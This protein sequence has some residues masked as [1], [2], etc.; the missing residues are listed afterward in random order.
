MAIKFGR[1]IQKGLQNPID[2]FRII[3]NLPKFVKLYLRLFQDR[4]VPLHLKLMLILAL[5]YVIS[6]IDL[7]P[8]WLLPLFGHVDDLI[9]LIATLRYFLR[10]CPP[11]AV[12]Q[13]VERIER[14]L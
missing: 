11:E 12:Q 8:D 4:R 6:P 2:F 10:N 3:L 7:I 9:I 14:G 5:V 1:L 13:H